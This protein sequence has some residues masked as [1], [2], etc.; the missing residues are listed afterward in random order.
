[1]ELPKHAVRKGKMDVRWK[2]VRMNWNLQGCTRVLED[3]EPMQVAHC[4]QASNCSVRSNLP[5][6]LVAFI[7]Q[8]NPW[9][10]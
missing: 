1:M 4:F 7:Q 10:L 9:E 5:A 2:K 8:P 3:N 6:K